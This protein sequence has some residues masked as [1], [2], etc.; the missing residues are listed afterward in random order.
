MGSLWVCLLLVG[1]AEEPGRVVRIP[2]GEGGELDVTEVVAR[3]ADRAGIEVQRPTGR[4]T[5]PMEGL[6]GSLTRT[7]LA[8]SLGEDV[9]LT[10][11]AAEVLAEIAPEALTAE[12][13]PRLRVRLVDLADRAGKASKG[14]LN[15]GMHALSSYRPNDPSRP[16]ICLVHGLNSTSAVFKHWIRPLEEVGFGV[17]VYDFPYNRDLHQTAPAF[18]RD[19]A[20]FRKEAGE[21]RPWAIVAHSMGALLARGYVEGDDGSDGDVSDLI[22]IAPVN[23]G[24][25]LAKAQ[26]LLQLVKGVQAVKDRKADAMANLTDGLGEAADDLVPGS[27]FLKKLN[28]RPRRAGVDYHILAGDAGFLTPAARRRIELQVGAAGRVGGVF[29][30]LARLATGDLSAQLDALTDGLG[31]G[32]VSLD[33]T[34][35]EGVEDHRTIHANHLEL[36]RAPLLFPEPGPIAGLP[37]VLERLGV[38]QAAKP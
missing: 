20:A 18:G 36:I 37:F 35:L 10:Y 17:V 23:G 28:A 16:T 1:L 5:L 31:D 25:A 11:Q 2:I 4:V 3:L 24:S 34:R 12:R 38:A 29:G 22:L 32:C 6:A 9:A 30:G 14:R 27:A 33:A 8:D 13:L 19:W 26:A 7:L 21:S 15:Y